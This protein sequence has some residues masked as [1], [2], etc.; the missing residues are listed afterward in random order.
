M[1]L[2]PGSSLCG[3]HITKIIDFLKT[4]CCATL[5]HHTPC[6]SETATLKKIQYLKLNKCIT[7]KIMHNLIRNTKLKIASSKVKMKLRNTRNCVCPK[8]LSKKP[9][10]H[11][12]KSLI[13]VLKSRTSDEK[14]LWLVSRAKKD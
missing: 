12:E 4:L 8:G 13:A 6:P 3:S 1:K 2:K 10:F 7:N 11:L 5:L 14:L 9:C